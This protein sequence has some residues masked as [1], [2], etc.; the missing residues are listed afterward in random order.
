ME[1][2]IK[3]N[4][5]KLSI[6]LLLIV[7]VSIFGSKKNS[8]VDLY[9]LNSECAEKAQEYSSWEILQSTF[10]VKRQACFV[11]L[12]YRNPSG[13]M[14]VISDITH[15]KEIIKRPS[16]NLKTDDVT[17]YTNIAKEYEEVKVEIFGK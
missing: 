14:Y 2:F 5:F 1:K 3:Q 16:L 7:M 12:I 17:S 13:D 8:A 9:K 4:W 15:N 11:E 10:N 6:I